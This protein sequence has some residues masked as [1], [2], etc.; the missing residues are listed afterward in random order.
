MRFD[1]H[2][3]IGRFNTDHQIIITEILDHFHLIQSTL[4]D[5][6]CGN[7]VVFLH[8]FFFQRTTVYTDTDW[9]IPLSGTVNHCFHTLCR[10]D[11]ARID[12]DLICTVFHRRNGKSIIKMY[13]SHKWNMNLFFDLCK[14]FCR[15]HIR[16]RAADDLTSCAL[17]LQDLSN[18]CLH[19][20]CLCICHGLNCDG[21][22]AANDHITDS[23]FF[24]TS[25][26]CHFSSPFKINGYSQFFSTTYQSLNSCC[27]TIYQKKHYFLYFI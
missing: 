6:F 16:N 8:Q 5:S 15:F 9:N 12:T 19:I 23:H 1:T 22:I 14:C 3:D 13:V 11:I 18:R 4:H 2:H 26:L 27:F 17:Q 20:L 21:M 25:S 7:T 10:T 24:C